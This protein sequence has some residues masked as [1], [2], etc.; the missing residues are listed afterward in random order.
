MRSPRNACP[1]ASATACPS[2][3]AL[4]PTP[5][6]ATITETKRR[7]SLVPYSHSRG[8]MLAGSGIVAGLAASTAGGCRR[9]P[10]QVVHRSVTLRGAGADGGPAQ[11][12][13]C[14]TPHAPAARRR[15]RPPR[16][17][18]APA[19]PTDQRPRP[20]PPQL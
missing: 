17:P 10:S 15:Q 14:P 18:A 4:L 19:L 16:L 2:A 12:R 5:P 3:R 6:G 20:L 7:I 1:L 8:G 13:R 9:K 11:V